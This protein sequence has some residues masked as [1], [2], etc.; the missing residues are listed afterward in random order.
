[1]TIIHKEGN[2]NSH[3]QSNHGSNILQH[4]DGVRN[5]KATLQCVPQMVHYK[6]ELK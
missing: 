6:G 3:K 2:M 1:M 5:L 4:N